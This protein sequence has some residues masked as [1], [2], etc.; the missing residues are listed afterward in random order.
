MSEITTTPSQLLIEKVLAAAMESGYVQKAQ[1]HGQGYK[2][3]DDEAIT[4]KFRDAM[5]S[6]GVLV[7]PEE[8]A[9]TDLRVFEDANGKAPNVLVTMGGH[10]TVTDGA[11]TFRVSSL[12][13]G[14]DRGDKAIYKAMTGFKKYAYRHLVMMATGD[15]PEQT[16]EDEKPGFRAAVNASISK[17]A[18]Q[19]DVAYAPPAAPVNSDEA[20]TAQ[21]NLLRAKAREAGL[22]DEERKAVLLAATGK[23]SFKGLL[24]SD[25]DK[26][27]QAIESAA[28]AKT[29]TGGEIVG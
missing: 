4:T 2:Y 12:G 6:Q 9:V 19:A 28:Q 14:L 25:V 27:L 11:A 15:D 22:T 3:A 16:R 5:L 29:L 10:F 8:M 18:D 13:Q 21:K 7:F 1:T 17:A 23:H 20:T 24:R 26:M